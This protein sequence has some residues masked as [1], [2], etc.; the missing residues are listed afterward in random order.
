MSIQYY[1]LHTA[2]ISA[3]IQWF[4]VWPR[5]DHT[6]LCFS[7]KASSNQSNF[8][9]SANY[10]TKQQLW[11]HQWAIITGAPNDQGGTGK[12]TLPITDRGTLGECRCLSRQRAILKP[13]VRRNYSKKEELTSWEGCMSLEWERCPQ[14]PG[15]A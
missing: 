15:K 6:T 7:H 2:T 11:N 10:M 14:T 4:T 13:I 3:T 12:R 9:W 8:L 5:V 1:W